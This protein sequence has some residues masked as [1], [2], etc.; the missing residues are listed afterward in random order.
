MRL[1]L[2]LAQRGEGQVSPNPMV[3]CVIVKNDQIIGQGYHQQYGQPHAE[4]NAIKDTGD[5][6]LVTGSDV[7]VTLEPCAHQGKTPPCADLLA[8][9]KPAR[10]IIASLDSNPLVAGK[11]IQKLKD[12]GI[13]VITGIMDQESRALNVRFFSLMEKKRPYIILK[14]AQTADGF[15][16]GPQF[17][18]VQIS[19][20]NSQAALHRMRS[21]E[22]AILV[23]FNTAKHDNPS[24]TTRLVHGKNALRL[25]IDKRLE[26]GPEY[27]LT[28]QS[29]P[30]VCYNL[31]K[32]TTYSDLDFV[33][34]KDEDFVPQI[35]ADLATRK[36]CSLLVEGG[37]ELLKSFI[38]KGAWDEAR[39]FVSTKTLGQGIKAPAFDFEIH[40]TSKL[41]S[42]LLHTYF[43]SAV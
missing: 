22:D 20:Q 18:Q 14:W 39:V 43:H 29:T 7:Y 19:N 36:V 23:G 24:L 31:L 12:N 35:L 15:I 10:V 4:P 26:L 27:H 11:G 37:A 13:E 32:H 34:L 38:Q 28:D 5:E 30:T 3:G 8:R 2:G 21:Q 17:Q 33:Q 25:F 9:L 1:A 42:D 16:A 41:G 40:Q 6:R